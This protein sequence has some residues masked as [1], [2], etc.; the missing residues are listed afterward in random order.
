MGV[1]AYGGEL[2]IAP[3]A[4]FEKPCILFRLDV[5]DWSDDDSNHIFG[6]A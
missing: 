2:V 3:S 6:F 1:I 4:I 5:D